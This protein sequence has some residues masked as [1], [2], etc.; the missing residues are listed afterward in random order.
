MLQ[1]DDYFDVIFK[2][3]YM[4]VGFRSA[5]LVKTSP[6]NASGLRNRMRTH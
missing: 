2:Y 3:K 5:R 6:A 1:M 4:F